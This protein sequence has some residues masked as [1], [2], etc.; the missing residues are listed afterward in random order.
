MYKRKYFN[1]TSNLKATC[2]FKEN[3]LTL[4]QFIS[5]IFASVFT[6]VSVIGFL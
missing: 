1:D 5:E 6:E 3:Y 4:K 2:I